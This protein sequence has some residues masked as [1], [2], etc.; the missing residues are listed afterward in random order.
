MRTFLSM[1]NL[2][3]NPVSVLKL[4]TLMTSMIPKNS[5]DIC[6]KP[7]HRIAHQF[8]RADRRA[9]NTMVDLSSTSLCRQRRESLHGIYLGMLR[10]SLMSLWHRS[11]KYQGADAWGRN[12]PWGFE[13]YRRGLK[14][15]P[16]LAAGIMVSYFKRGCSRRFIERDKW[17]LCKGFF[18]GR[19][20]I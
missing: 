7:M 15:R 4:N 5:I 8:Q 1:Q 13:Y 11:G 6:T 2:P 12:S 14:P 19:Q 10:A 9:A 3:V 17:Q 20:N 16:L 18:N